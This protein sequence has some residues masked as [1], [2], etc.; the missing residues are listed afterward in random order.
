MRILILLFLLTGCAGEEGSQPETI[1]PVQ[2]QATTPAPTSQQPTSPPPATPQ[3]VSQPIPEV[4]PPPPPPDKLTMAFTGTVGPDGT[5]SGTF[6]Y[7]KAQGPTDT[8]VRHLKEN[9][10]YQ[11][12]DWDLM[13]NSASMEDLLPSTRYQKEDQGNSVEFCLGYCVFASPPLISL[14]FRNDTNQILFLTF[15]MQDPT[16]MIN[17]PSSVSEWG[18]LILRG[19]EYR[20]PGPPCGPLALFK[21][22]IVQEQMKTPDTG[23]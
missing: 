1:T 22:G 7:I 14:T 6:T 23:I 12:E 21:N 9:V 8:N 4:I 10:V 18:P 17:P 3:P 5:V 11:L 20:V 2:Q 16:P 15:E 13:V 19:S